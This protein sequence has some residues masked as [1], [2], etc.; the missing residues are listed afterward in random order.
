MSKL[1]G[2]DTV[3]TILNA[4]GEQDAQAS[5][6]AGVHLDKLCEDRDKGLAKQEKYLMTTVLNMTKLLCVAVQRRI[7]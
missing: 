3:V 6:R 7:T 2:K 1:A 4:I 5:I